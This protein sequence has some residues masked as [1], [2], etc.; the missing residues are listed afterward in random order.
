MEPL[1]KLENHILLELEALQEGA[2]KIGKFMVFSQHL[3]IQVMPE[4]YALFKVV[5][6]AHLELQ[7]MHID[8]QQYKPRWVIGGASVA[9]LEL[10][11]PSNTTGKWEDELDELVDLVAMHCTKSALGKVS[12]PP[13]A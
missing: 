5:V 13:K 8:I 1:E 6:K 11:F 9:P 7:P 12:L 3:V 4:L 10:E 2:W